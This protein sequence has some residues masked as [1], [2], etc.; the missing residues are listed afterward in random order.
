MKR[1]FQYHPWPINERNRVVPAGLAHASTHA[2]LPQEILECWLQNQNEDPLMFPKYFSVRCPSSAIFHVSVLEY[3]ADPGCVYLPTTLFEQHA[4]CNLDTLLLQQVVL[5][6]ATWMLLQPSLE[7]KFEEEHIQNIVRAGYHVVEVGT[8]I[9]SDRDL[10]YR[11]IAMEPGRVASTIDTDIAIELDDKLCSPARSGAADTCTLPVTP[12]PL[13][14][15]QTAALRSL[16]DARTTRQLE[17]AIVSYAGPAAPPLAQS[18]VSPPAAPCNEL[19]Q[20]NALLRDLHTL[21]RQ[22]K[23]AVVS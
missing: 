2:I 3:T 10:R 15:D 14:C 8:E 23:V 7:A 11:V 12:S 5:P 9:V 4:L 6:H 18:P 22:R 1:I 19:S 16:D 13:I 20:T 21:R 17:T